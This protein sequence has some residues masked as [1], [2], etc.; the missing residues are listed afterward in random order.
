MLCLL[1][2]SVWALWFKINTSYHST[3]IL[4]TQ[5]SMPCIRTFFIN[6][7]IGLMTPLTHPHNPLENLLIHNTSRRS[8]CYKQAIHS[9]HPHLLNH[10]LVT[11]ASLSLLLL[12]PPK[13]DSAVEEEEPLPLL[14]IIMPNEIISDSGA[15][16]GIQ[17]IRRR[18]LEYTLRPETIASNFSVKTIQ[19]E[20][21][22]NNNICNLNTP[23]NYLL[24]SPT[25]IDINPVYIPPAP[26]PPPPP[27]LTPGY[28]CRK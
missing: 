4:I 10:P 22:H 17:W 8:F 1:I 25:A 26:A 28:E 21:I 13:W 7:L 3:S 24:Y 15:F 5:F 27:P 19:S 23:L 20:G 14:K 16:Y 9:V 11:R 2:Y 6:P 18:R 12:P